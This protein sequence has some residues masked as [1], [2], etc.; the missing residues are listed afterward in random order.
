MEYPTFEA[1]CR[2]KWQC[3]RNDFDRLISAAHVHNFLVTACHQNKPE[4]EA[5]IR[6]LLGLSPRAV[7]VAWELA[8]TLADGRKVSSTHVKQAI[9]VT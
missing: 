9:M 3:G 8:V 2:Q 7:Q 4:H 1:F 5:Q 6:P